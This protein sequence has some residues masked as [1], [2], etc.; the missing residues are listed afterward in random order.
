[1]KPIYYEVRNAHSISITQRNS[2]YSSKRIYTYNKCHWLISYP[3]TINTFDLK[4]II[5]CSTV[6]M[7]ISIPES[8][9][10]VALD[11][12]PSWTMQ[13]GVANVSN[14]NKKVKN[15]GWVST[16]W[17][18]VHGWMDWYWTYRSYTM[19]INVSGYIIS[20]MYIQNHGSYWSQHQVHYGK[21]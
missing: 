8:M 14:F 18:V 21:K 2:I 15:D 11:T 16:V 6:V 10:K 3:H 17:R 12:S 7:S 20:A 13:L 9:F 4:I 5:R 19:R 1:M